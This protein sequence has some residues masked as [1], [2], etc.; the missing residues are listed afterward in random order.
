MNIFTNLPFSFKKFHISDGDST[1]LY[2]V[3]S[4]CKKSCSD[5]LSNTF[6]DATLIEPSIP[7]RNFFGVS[8]RMHCTSFLPQTI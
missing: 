4:A 1:W 8:T 3:L 6:E 5:Q 2:T 7:K